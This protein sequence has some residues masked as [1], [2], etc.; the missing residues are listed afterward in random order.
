[1]EIQKGAVQVLLLDHGDFHGVEGFTPLALRGL[2]RILEEGA[3]AALF[4]LLQEALGSLALLDQLTD[5]VASAL[6]NIAVERGAK[7]GRWRR[8]ADAG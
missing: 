4:L 1:M 7:R 2:L 5:A 3:A 8:P 6:Q